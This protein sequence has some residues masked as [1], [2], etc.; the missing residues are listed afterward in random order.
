MQMSHTELH[1]VQITQGATVGGCMHKINTPKSQ[2]SQK[3]TEKQS[4]LA[5]TDCRHKAEEILQEKM[6]TEAAYGNKTTTNSYTIYIYV[7]TIIYSI[8]IIYNYNYITTIND[9][10]LLLIIWARYISLRP[11]AVQRL[12]I[13]FPIEPAA[14]YELIGMPYNENRVCGQ[15]LAAPVVS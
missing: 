9:C 15:M 8:Y 4:E 13:A 3:A 14:G 10:K 1:H 2:K 11:N 5:R 12:N 7:Y 6:K